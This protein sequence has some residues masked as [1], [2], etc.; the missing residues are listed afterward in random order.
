MKNAKWEIFFPRDNDKKLSEGESADEDEVVCEA[1]TELSWRAGDDSPVEAATEADSSPAASWVGLPNENDIVIE[2]LSGNQENFDGVVLKQ[3]FLEFLELEW[4]LRSPE[5]EEK[6]N[7]K[8]KNANWELDS[9]IMSI[10]FSESFLD[11]YLS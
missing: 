11:C 5:E 7:K 8:R 6:K 1:G 4:N 2:I 9:S 3:E 10:F